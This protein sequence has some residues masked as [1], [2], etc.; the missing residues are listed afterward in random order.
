MF[1]NT[2]R[3]GHRIRVQIS[4]SFAPHLSRN[5][6]T[7]ESEVFS[8]QARVAQILIHHGGEFASSIRLPLVATAG[9]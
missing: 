4:A 2:F 7:G 1:A 6:Q 3:E 8:A 9:D 5:L